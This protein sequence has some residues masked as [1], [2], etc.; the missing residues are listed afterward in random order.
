MASSSMSRLATLGIMTAAQLANAKTNTPNI[1]PS[2]NTKLN[3]AEHVSNLNVGGASSGSTGYL[4]SFDSDVTIFTTDSG[5]VLGLS[6]GISADI[7]ASLS[8]PAFSITNNQRDWLVVN[9]H[10]FAEG[11]VATYVTIKL[12]LVELTLSFKVLGFKFSPLDF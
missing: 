2:F 9:P 6:Q 11:S 3:D 8:S 5:A 10:I 1:S 12:I 7:F 4:K